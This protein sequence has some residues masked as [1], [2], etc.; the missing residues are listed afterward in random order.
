MKILIDLLKKHS[1]EDPISNIDIAKQ[2]NLPP[3]HNGADGN[4]L[5]KL[6]N[7]LR[8]Q[9]FPILGNSRGYYLA[10]TKQDIKEYIDRRNQHIQNDINNLE[11]I[12]RIYSQWNSKNNGKNGKK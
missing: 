10:Q 11:I 3:R 6:I 8:L 7:D 5:R 9:G 1:P 12:K 2:L 4:D